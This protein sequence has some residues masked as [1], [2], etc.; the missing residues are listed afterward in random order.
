MTE[1]KL[2]PKKKA[3]AP[4]H[5]NS[6]DPNTGG[7][8]KEIWLCKYSKKLD[9]ELWHKDWIYYRY[10]ERLPVVE[11]YKQHYGKKVRVLIRGMSQPYTFIIGKEHYTGVEL[12]DEIEN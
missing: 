12:G 9:R 11:Y 5:P 2:E 7:F 3:K 4:P 1:P 10:R 6:F 8:V